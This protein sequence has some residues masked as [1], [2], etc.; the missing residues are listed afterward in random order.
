M[1]AMTDYYKGAVIYSLSFP[2]DPRVYV[3]STARFAARMRQHCHQ[4]REGRHHC[5]K[6]RR[7]ATKFGIENLIVVI[8][9]RIESDTD[10]IARE[11]FW[12]GMFAG[13]LFNTCPNAASRLG[14]KMPKSAIE[15]NRARLIGNKRRLGIPHDEETKSRIGATLRSLYASGERTPRPSPQNLRAFNEAIISGTRRHPS[16]SAPGRD[17]KIVAEFYRTRSA[18]AVGALHGIKSDAIYVVLRK[19][20]RAI[21]DRLE[22]IGY[23]PQYL[24]KGPARCRALH[25]E[26]LELL[27]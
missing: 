6:L 22:A 5:L 10:L 17:E 4:L 2:A 16:R 9:E 15:A 14:A 21:E 11:Q 12:M 24:S 1:T 19:Q 7:A 26:W 8:L 27:Q 25:P 3:G 13:R 23:P 18:D 20:K